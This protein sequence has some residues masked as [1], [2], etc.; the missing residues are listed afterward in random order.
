MTSQPARQT[1]AI[2]QEFSPKFNL[3]L[4]DVPSLTGLSVKQKNRITGEP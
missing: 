3:I 1:A 2:Q 4:H